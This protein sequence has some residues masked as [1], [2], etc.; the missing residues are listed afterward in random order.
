MLVRRDEAAIERPFNNLL[1]RLNMV[2]S[3]LRR[4]PATANVA[5]IAFGYQFFALGRFAIAYRAI[6]GETPSTTLQRSK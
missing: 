4:A 1:R 5:E 2:R 6:F 3:A